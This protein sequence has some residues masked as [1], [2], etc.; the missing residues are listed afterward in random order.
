MLNAGTSFRLW[1]V[2]AF[3]VCLCFGGTAW[4]AANPYA[5]DTN[6]CET[7]TGAFSNLTAYVVK[8]RVRVVKRL[9]CKACSDLKTVCWACDVPAHPKTLRKLDDGRV[10]CSLDFKDAVLSEAEARD[11]FAEVKREVLSLLAHW[12]PRPET[13]FVVHLVNQDDFI[14]EVRRKPVLDHPE[15]LL[16]LTHS[17]DI[18]TNRYEH[19]IYLLSGLPKAQF[20]A[21][22]AHEYTHAWLNEHSSKARLLHKDTEEGF[23]ELMAWKYLTA[24][25][26][27]VEAERLLESTYTHGQVNTLVTAEQQFGFYRLV[28]WILHGVDSW[29]DKE[30]PARLLALNRDVAEPEPATS[31]VWSKP[32]LTAVPA[33]LLLKGISTGRA[34][35]LALVNDQTLARNESGKVRIGTSNVVVKCLEI[36]DSSVLLQVEG[37][38][39][40][41]ELF[42]HRALR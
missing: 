14:R 39:E 25:N 24:Q 34:G 9:I 8:D 2:V 18:E 32:V 21:V 33:T 1:A 42:L 10:L 26:Y 41:M 36:R 35:R 15:H 19:F 5:P 6:R 23:C 30:T 7:C 17:D 3:C 40:P 11:L 38:P 28:T 20:R 22:C 13:N 27:R 4:P 37:R 12:R 29:L 16:G 31:F